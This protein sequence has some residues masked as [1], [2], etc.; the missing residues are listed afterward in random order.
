MSVPTSTFE[1]Y[2]AVGIR[3][4]LTDEIYNVDPTDTPLLTAFGKVKATQPLHEW[5]TDAFAAA[6][7]SN[8]VAEGDDATNDAVTAT[9]RLSN[10][11]QISDKVIQISGTQE[12]SVK[13]GRKSEMG[14][15]IAKAAKELKRDMEAIITRNGAEVTGSSGTARQL[16][17]ILSWLE[18]NTSFGTGGADGTVG[19][20]ARTDGTQ[21]VFTED[22]LTAALQ[23]VWSNG[24]DPDIISVGAFNKRKM[25]AFSGNATR[26]V[27]AMEQ[28]L[29][30][31]IDIYVSDWGRH[32]IVPDRFQRSR[33][34]LILQ[35][36]MWALAYLRTFNIADLA[37]TG[38]SN[39]KQML[40]EYTLESRNE[41]ASGGVFDLTVS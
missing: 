39:R 29:N 41:K 21:R 37:K 35:T 8:A 2:A 7:S 5:Q 20:T 15:Q 40:V 11:C 4:D 6:S 17:A 34:A 3:D 14:Y 9:V 24:G 36:D 18:T 25:S 1:T 12:V 28:E 16:G 31:A 19:N 23:D 32:K 10:T 22:M 27:D 26:Y 13:A 30:A 33:D 38:D